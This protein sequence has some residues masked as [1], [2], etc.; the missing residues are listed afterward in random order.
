MESNDNDTLYLLIDE[1]HCCKENDYWATW[2]TNF[3]HNKQNNVLLFQGEKK[4]TAKITPPTIFDEQQICLSIKEQNFNGSTIKIF[5][6]SHASSK[7][8]KKNQKH[9]QSVKKTQSGITQS[10]DGLI[11]PNHPIQNRIN[12]IKQLINNNNKL[13]QIEIHSTACYGSYKQENDNGNK[14]D[15][16]YELKQLLQS[17]NS[18]VEIT[19]KLSP[20]QDDGT[21]IEIGKDG[22]PHIK[23]GLCDIYDTND[24]SYLIQP[25]IV[26]TK[27]DVQIKYNK[28]TQS[29]EMGGMGDGVSFFMN[30]LP[31][32]INYQPVKDD[33]YLRKDFLPTKNGKPVNSKIYEKNATIPEAPQVAL[34]SEITKNTD[35]LC[36]L[37]TIKC[38]PKLCW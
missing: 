10:F 4:D 3:F 19:L 33:I 27:N 13:K 30:L 23:Y 36:N 6:L 34:N 28:F 24:F 15:Y 14:I 25:D 2:G 35:W 7:F 8:V 18:N 1:K 9:K 20:V 12:I 5:D 17:L 26:I 21:G 22:K 38:C 37:N 16:I 31:D 11:S 32:E 29:E